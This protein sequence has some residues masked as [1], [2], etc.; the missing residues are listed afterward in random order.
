MSP[1]AVARLQRLKPEPRKDEL[2]TS[3]GNVQLPQHLAGAFPQQRYARFHIECGIESGRGATTGAMPSRNSSTA[4]SRRARNTGEGRPHTQQPRI[5]RWH[6]QTEP[7]P[8]RFVDDLSTDKGDAC[9][10]G[11]D[12]K[13]LPLTAMSLANGEDTRPLHR[14]Y[15]RRKSVF[16]K[17]SGCR[18]FCRLHQVLD[19]QR[20]A[21]PG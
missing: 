9:G 19:F 7:L 15:F 10:F 6:R 12:D 16:R 21:F 18:S 8:C 11:N 4:W 2:E 17:Y 14:R 20:F 5:R 13:R 1:I 3:L